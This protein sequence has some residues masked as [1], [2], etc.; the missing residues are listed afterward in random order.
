MILWRGL[1]AIDVE[2]MDLA[3]ALI[4]TLGS[5][6]PKHARQLAASLKATDRERALR[7]ELAADVAAQMLKSAP[8]KPAKAAQ[9]N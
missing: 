2:I 8:A 5:G 3:K 1:V 9:G 4:D 7:Y 6:A